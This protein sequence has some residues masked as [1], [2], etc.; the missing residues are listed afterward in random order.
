MGLM[1]VNCTSANMP[2]KIAV[3]CLGEGTNQAV[4]ERRTHE[5]HPLKTRQPVDKVVFEQGYSSSLLYHAVIVITARV[6]DFSVE[7]RLSMPLWN[8]IQP[9]NGYPSRS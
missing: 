2:G 3:D 6:V 1:P 8:H 5:V 7:Q 9:S 4:L